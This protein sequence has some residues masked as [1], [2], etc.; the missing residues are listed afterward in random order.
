[1]SINHQDGR[2][3]PAISLRPLL[4]WLLLASALSTTLMVLGAGRGDQFLPSLSA[5]HQCAALVA[6]NSARGDAAGQPRHH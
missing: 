2:Y 6:R 4:P 5:G 1:M 3:A